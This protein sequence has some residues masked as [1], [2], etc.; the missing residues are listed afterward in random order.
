MCIS[1]S[2]FDLRSLLTLVPLA[3]NQ[4]P[5]S[6]HSS[7]VTEVTGVEPEPSVVIT[8]MESQLAPEYFL[9]HTNVKAKGIIFGTTSSPGCLRVEPW[10]V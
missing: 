1:F 10:E 2:H 7:E 6:Q 3:A 9:L 5:S 4:L 8:N